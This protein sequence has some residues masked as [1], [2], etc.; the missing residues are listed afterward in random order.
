MARSRQAIVVRLR[1]AAYRLMRPLI[2]DGLAVRDRRIDTVDSALVEIRGCFDDQA[3]F[4]LALQKDLLATN[5]RID[6]L[7]QRAE[8]S[9][10]ESS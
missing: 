7:E 9:G 2:V 4:I 6:W 1:S 10:A 5:R 8:P 3:T